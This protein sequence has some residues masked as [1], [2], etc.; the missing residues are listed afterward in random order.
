MNIDASQIKLYST[1]WSPRKT[2]DR[3]HLETT[4][5]QERLTHPKNNI[6]LHNT[7]NNME[8]HLKKNTPCVSKTKANIPKTLRKRTMSTS[9]PLCLSLCPRRTDHRPLHR[10]RRHGEVC[11]RPHQHQLSAQ[12][13]AGKND[14][15]DPLAQAAPGGEKSEM[16][17]LIKLFGSGAILLRKMMML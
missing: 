17:I 15:A 9:Q 7:G 16:Q 11:Q 12:R 14:A 6:Y 1:D 8:Q 3:K 13:A 4:I 10:H 5:F 2:S